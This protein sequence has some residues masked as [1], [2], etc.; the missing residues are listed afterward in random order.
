MDLEDV[1][2]VGGTLAGNALSMTAMK[3]TLQNI[4]TKENFDKMV[5]LSN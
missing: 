5:Q 3:A 4:F 1:G 2:G